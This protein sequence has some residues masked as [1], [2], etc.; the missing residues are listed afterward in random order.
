MADC[1]NRAVPSYYAVE[2][3]LE[4]PPPSGRIEVT[5]EMIAAAVDSITAHGLP[6]EEVYTFQRA[7]LTPSEIASIG[8]FTAEYLSQ[9][10]LE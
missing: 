4:D 3:Q 10:Q 6:P 8:S 2:S 5:S 7:G 9:L 1:L